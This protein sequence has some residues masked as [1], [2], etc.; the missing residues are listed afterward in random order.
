MNRCLLF[1]LSNLMC[2]YNEFDPYHGF[3]KIYEHGDVFD[4]LLNL[5]QHIHYLWH[6]SLRIQIILRLCVSFDV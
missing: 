2:I 6:M 5:I 4:W 1:N 3:H